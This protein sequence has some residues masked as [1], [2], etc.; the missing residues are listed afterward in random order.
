MQERAAALAARKSSVG[1]IGA[2]KGA[3][4]AEAEKRAIA[5]A[6]Y[7]KQVRSSDMHM[8]CVHIHSSRV[9]GVGGRGAGGGRGVQAGRRQYGMQHNGSAIRILNEDV[10]SA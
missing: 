10:T 1:G 2:R 5:L 6:E 7:K 3:A 8:H 9:F 4:E